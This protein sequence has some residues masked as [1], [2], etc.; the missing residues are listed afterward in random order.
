MCT[1]LETSNYCYL[2]IHY[3]E[4]RR[5]V[6]GG[7]PPPPGSRRVIT[8]EW[9]PRRKSEVEW[10]R[11]CF[12]QLTPTGTGAK[13]E[14]PLHLSWPSKCG[15]NKDGR[16]SSKRRRRRLKARRA[17]PQSNLRARS[18]I[19]VSRDLIAHAS[20]FLNYTLC[21]DCFYFSLPP[22]LPF[23]NTDVNGPGYLS[24]LICSVFERNAR[25]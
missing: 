22:P 1:V 9:K 25:K 11:R 12:F 6:P 24:N 2:S 10:N 7:S 16:S 15:L 14:L 13:C 17:R 4:I 3:T 23:H 5:Q 8:R 20:Y 19:I 21:V 18:L